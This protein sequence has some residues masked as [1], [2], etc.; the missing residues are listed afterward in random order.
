[1]N[2]KEVGAAAG[3]GNALTERDIDVYRRIC[4]RQPID[5]GDPAVAESFSKLLHLHLVAEHPL[6]PELPV[7]MPPAHAERRLAELEQQRMAEAAQRMKHT[8]RMRDV[9]SPLFEASRKQV[10]EGGIEV[11][12]GLAAIRDRLRFLTAG[13]TEE[14]LTAQPGARSQEILDMSLKVDGALLERGLT[15]RTIYPSTARSRAPECAWAA[16]MSGKGAQ[17]RT[18]SETFNRII[19]V[20]GRKKGFAHAF[21][22]DVTNPDPD[23]AL[24]IT[25][26]G[27]VA[28]LHHEFMTAWQRADPWQGERLPQDVPDSLSKDQLY[29]LR[30]LGSGMQDQQLARQMGISKRTMTKHMN[31][32]YE[33]LGVESGSRFELGLRWAELKQQLDEHQPA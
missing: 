5:M 17:I 16:T 28:H 4:M 11:L 10:D 15:M 27:M 12:E 24:H 20:D 9:L 32:L 21:I 25:H 18:L 19:L 26:P 3:S 13:A 14:L 2:K 29:I 7:A 22:V 23:A 1:M 31:E 8:A 33:L 30:C 6:Q